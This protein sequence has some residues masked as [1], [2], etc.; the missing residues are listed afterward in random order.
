MRRLGRWIWAVGPV[1]LYAGLIVYLSS[2]SSLPSVRVNDKILH[3]AEYAAL[4]FLINRA[5][6][7]LR[8]EAA[9]RRATLLAIALST[10]FG[11]SDELH[12]HFVPN[13][14]ASFG[15]LVADFLGSTAGALA[16][17]AW[18]DLRGRLVRR[19]SAL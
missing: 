13:R 14:D 16:Y 12:Q 19:I 11:L 5:F 1:A 15:D 6:S 7:L 10:A 3:F 8:P 18:A 2:R 4:A 17:A 9:P